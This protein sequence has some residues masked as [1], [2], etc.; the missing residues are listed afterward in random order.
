MA[1]SGEEPLN[2]ELYRV[3]G[4]AGWFSW[5]GI[6]SIEREALVE[7][8][9]G[10]TLSKTPKIYKEYRDF[11]INKYRENPRRPL[12][13]TEIRKMLVGDVN[14]LRRVFEFLELWGLINYHPDPAEAVSSIVLPSNSSA[15]AAPP[16]PGIQIVSKSFAANPA[17]NLGSRENAFHSK[18]QGGGGGKS[19]NS[20]DGSSSSEWTAEETMLLLEAISKYGDNWNRV[21]QH[22][23]SKN[24]GQCVR[25]FIQLPFGDQFLNEDLGAV[26]SSSPVASK[27]LEN[28]TSHEVRH[29]TKKQKLSHT[30]AKAAKGAQHAHQA[31]PN[32]ASAHQPEAHHVLEEVTPLTDASNPLLSQIAFMSAMVGPRVAAAAAQAAL[33][34]LAEEEPAVS[35]LPFLNQQQ[36][37]Q[38]HPHQQK[39]QQL[40]KEQQQPKEQQQQQ[41]QDEQVAAD[42]EENKQ[43]NAENDSDVKPEADATPEVKQQQ[44]S[45]EPVEDKDQ[46]AKKDKEETRI[47]AAKLRAGLAT[48]M[49]AAAVNA[50]QLADREERDME[51]LMANIIE[52]QLKKLYS[53]LD[54]FEELEQLM[55]IE[56]LQ[57]QQ[58]REQVFVDRLQL[59][60]QQH[61]SAATV[62]A[63][64]ATS[65]QDKPSS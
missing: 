59:M 29:P 27:S 38:H 46:H 2:R 7:F 23:G 56:R 50:K 4:H 24:R 51:L 25:Q 53:K 6:H 17:S 20:P 36:Q 3:P 54:H 12:T 28:G 8:F 61:A 10:K 42:K 43:N 52:S 30:E 13:F 34:V 33:A 1:G 37:Q 32:T 65:A 5:T 16:P 15:A 26:S 18:Q 22:V 21:Q 45:A 39:G 58:M 49:A 11:I 64:A 62:A 35:Q 57:L 63:S 14:C 44:P 41:Q 31:A 47:S 9:E 55:D 19:Q 60:R 48:A 40:S